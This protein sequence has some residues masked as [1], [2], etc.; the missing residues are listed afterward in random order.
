MWLDDA[1]VIDGFARARARFHELHADGSGVDAG[2]EDAASALSRQPYQ[3][4]GIELFAERRIDCDPQP[5]A[6]AE[7]AIDIA[8][9][10]ARGPGS[11]LMGDSAPFGAQL[12]A[13]CFPRLGGCRNTRRRI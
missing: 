5:G 7:Y 2:Q 4:C 11:L 13:K 1:E 6:Q 10:E 3:R 8:G 9:N 12:G